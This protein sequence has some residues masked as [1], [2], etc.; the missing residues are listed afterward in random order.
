MHNEIKH[1]QKKFFALSATISFA[2]IFIML[3]VLNIL[4]N[5]SFN[6]ELKAAADIVSQTAI[7]NAPDM[8]HETILLSDTQTDENGNYIIERNPKS[9]QNITING[10]ILCTNDKAEWYCAGGGVYF[11]YPIDHLEKPKLIHKEYKFNQG[12]TKIIID[13]T[14]D[15]TFMCDEKPFEATIDQ[16]SDKRFYISPVW[17][18]MASTSYD[19]HNTDVELIINNIEIQYRDNALV[20]NFTFKEH[21]FNDVYPSGIPYT[22]NNFQCFYIINDKQDR[23]VEFNSGNTTLSVKSQKVSN[24][25]KNNTYGDVKFDNISYKHFFSETNQFDIHVF[26]H[27]TLTEKSGSRLLIISVLCG[28]GAFVMVLVIIYFVSG[29][30]VRPIKE[31]Y[32]KQNEFISNASHELKTPITVI[33]ATTQLMEKKNGTDSLLNCIQVQSKKMGRL[34]NEMLTLTRITDSAKQP[35]EFEQ[36]DLSRAVINNVL[37]FEGRAFE[38]GKKI[39]TDIQ[40]NILFE[41]NQNKIDE[42]IGILLDNALKYSDEKSVIEL[43]LHSEKRNIILTC[44]NKCENFDPDN[45]THLFERFYRGDKSHSERREGFGLGL[46]IAYEIVNIHN[47]DIAV[48][49]RED[50]VIF[51]IKI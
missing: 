20:E 17:W 14:D 49:Y 1:L 36:F 4:M 3:L 33:S 10:E 11:E 42:L 19:N 15:S 13:F 6:N 27:N 22:L 35:N 34:V 31:G 51:E 38:E 41:G 50:Y 37:Y 32:K 46:A 8:D 18:S 43:S 28:G 25:M 44:K 12:N 9:I 16:V 26:M 47:G 30:A 7:S 45:I 48:D 5:V 39:K 29:R 40:E 24:I 21:N 23:P 2:V